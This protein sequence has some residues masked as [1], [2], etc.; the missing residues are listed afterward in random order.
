VINADVRTS[1]PIASLA[2]L[3]TRGKPPT[4]ASGTAL[5]GALQPLDLSGTPPNT[6]S[7][8]EARA[9]LLV[10]HGTVRQFFPYFGRPVPDGIDA[11]LDETL[12]TLLLAK[13]IDRP[14]LH[15]VLE[16]FGEVLHDGHAF[17]FGGAPPTIG[18]FLI[19]T[20]DVDG[21]PVVRRSATPGVRPG[22]TLVSVN[23]EPMERWLAR[24]YRHTSA[25]S[26]GYLQDKALRHLTTM[27]GPL[28][29]GLRAPDG[30]RRT[31]S[32]TPA[33]LDAY[34]AFGG[35]PSLRPSG[36]LADLG[37]PNLYFLNLASEVTRTDADVLAA[38]TA[39]QGASGL[40]L[41]MR[42]YPVVDHYML[43]QRLISATFGSPRF[44]VPI[45]TYASVHDEA[46]G[47]TLDPIPD[48]PVFKGPIVLIVGN[49]TASAAE[50]FSI[51]L[52]DS[53]RV[54]V[55]GQPSAAT[56][57]N[58]TDVWLP[59]NEVF[60]FTGMLVEHADGKPFHGIGIVPDQVVSATPD[61]FAAGRDPEL[62]A[63]IA[64]LSSP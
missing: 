43:A 4:V 14:Q 16:R 60:S 29:V 17:V 62:L 3:A 28:E 23:G 42:G 50:N 30:T 34:R 48:A 27:T 35:A 5:R 41:D 1:T 10:A 20:E 61:D 32:V 24:T 37:A 63:A 40:V 33:T 7:L 44:T 47:F 19:T 53:K 38:L 55:V 12:L 25:A 54:T 11:R 21:L 45:R 31:V 57:G 15:E 59:G 52:V 18:Y 46:D 49:H 13:T 51:L 56:D 8:A 22:D 39:A 36:S 2:G 58:I 64:K 6:I 26:P 9:A